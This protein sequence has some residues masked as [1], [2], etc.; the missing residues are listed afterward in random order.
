[1]NDERQ[2]DPLKESMNNSSNMNSRK[3]MDS[4]EQYARYSCG[5]RYRKHEGGGVI[6]GLILISIGVLWLLDKFDYVQF[7]ISNLVSSFIDL[8]PLVL[9]VVGINLVFKS[10][11]IVHRIS[12][13]LFLGILLTYS[14]FGPSLFGEQF[15][16]FGNQIPGVENSE[17]TQEAMTQENSFGID[18]KSISMEDYTP[19]VTNGDIELNI[20][21]GDIQFGSDNDNLISYV[22]PSKIMKEREINVNGEHASL[23]FS[24]KD[25]TNTNLDKNGNFDFY[26]NKDVLWNV[27]VNTGALDGNFDF[28]DAHLGNLKINSGAGD[29]KVKVGSLERESKIE[30]NAAAADL[31][32]EIPEDSGVHVVVNGISDKSGLEKNGLIKSGNAYESA[33]YSDKTHKIIITINTPVSDISVDRY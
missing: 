28:E 5:D 12:W 19:I 21:A 1:M 17:Q 29:I 31:K 10:Y 16:L 30:I 9:V 18:S 4:N 24:Q 20:G 33:G 6:P 27:V 15:K 23:V 14:I 13:I 25:H 22:I 7:S 3:D 2:D 11:R 8:W 26:L 32:F